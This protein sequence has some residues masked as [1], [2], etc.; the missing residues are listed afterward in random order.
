MW[1]PLLLACTQPAVKAAPASDTGPAED[2]GEPDVPRAALQFRLPLTDV[3]LFERVIGV[4]HDPTVQDP[5][6][7]QLLCLDYDDR[8]FPH[9]YDE[10]TGSDFI[11]AGGFD[12]MDSGSAEI[13]AAADGEVVFAEDGHYDRCH[14]S[15]EKGSNSC[16]GYDMI[17]NKVA[18]RHTTGDVTW[19]YHMKNGSVAVEVGEQVVAGQHL[20]LV[21]SSGNSYTPHLHFELQNA[22]GEVIDPYAGPLSQPETWWCDQ[23]DEDGFPG[24]CDDE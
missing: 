17:A 4:D 6:I 1:L 8:T 5:G 19:Y 20:G 22:L 14:G 11:L 3:S 9:C 10:H 15:L 16:D 13:V 12:Q 18:L 2:T 23:G 24:L 21:G 7:N